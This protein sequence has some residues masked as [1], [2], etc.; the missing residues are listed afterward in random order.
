MNQYQ[1]NHCFPLNGNYQNPEARGV[2]EVLGQYKFALQGTELS[3]P[4]YFHP[5]ISTAV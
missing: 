4:T 5:I 2:S 1:V 3:G